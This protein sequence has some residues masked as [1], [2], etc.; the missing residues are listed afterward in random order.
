MLAF[1]HEP[2]ESF[3]W[4][5]ILVY[6][7]SA[8]CLVATVVF[9]ILA[10]TTPHVYQASG[11]GDLFANKSIWFVLHFKVSMNI[12]LTGSSFLLH[13]RILKLLPSSHGS[14]AA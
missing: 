10:E 13:E 9:T 8:A 4:W 12:P 7:V 1:P 11:Y 3:V 5:R 14:M 2:W 6:A